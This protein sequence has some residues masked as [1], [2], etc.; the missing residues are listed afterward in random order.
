[1]ALLLSCDSLCKSFGPRPLF[2]G[3]TLHLED[4][5]RTGLIGP[6][7]SGK[8]T[9]L[10]ILAGEET[11]DSGAITSRRQIRLGY[12]PQNDIFPPG[13]TVEQVLLE[14]LSDAHGDEHEH[15]TQAA[16]LLGKIGFTDF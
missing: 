16:I 9:L 5:Q 3:I 8:S 10:K 7:G 12:L 6:N 4:N 13:L 1:M 11:A 14:V 15:Q 2:T